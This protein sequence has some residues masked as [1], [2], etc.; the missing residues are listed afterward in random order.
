M[1]AMSE[2]QWIEKKL[3][4]KTGTIVKLSPRQEGENTVFW[5]FLSNGVDMDLAAC[6]NIGVTLI[7]RHGMV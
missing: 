1:D 5:K 6:Y 2:T 7:I 4:E 3:S